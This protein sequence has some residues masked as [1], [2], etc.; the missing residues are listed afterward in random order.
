MLLD[1]EW[2]SFWREIMINGRRRMALWEPDLK[3]AWLRPLPLFVVGFGILN[4]NEANRDPLIGVCVLV[5]AVALLIYE[6]RKA[7]N[8]QEVRRK[9]LQRRER[10]TGS[11][12]MPRIPY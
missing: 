4:Q 3:L 10:L 7:R 8:F 2:A 1:R 9:Y 5:L 11:A 6:I 12:E